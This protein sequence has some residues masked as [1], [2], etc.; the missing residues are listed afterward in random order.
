VALYAASDEIHQAF[1]PC[2]EAS[3]WDILLD[4]TGAAISLLCL[5]GIGKLRKRW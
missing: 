5:W 4:T 2:R 3:V 1:V